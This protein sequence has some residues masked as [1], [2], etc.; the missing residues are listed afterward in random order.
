VVAVTDVHADPELSPIERE[1]MIRWSAADDRAHVASEEP[2]VI[3]W[4]LEHPEYEE[5]RSRSDSEGQTFSKGRLPVGCVKLSGES[6][7]DNR[8]SRVLGQLPE[9]SADE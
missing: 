8:H 7:S 3:R 2:A 6:R 1:T 5:I 4:L 9:D